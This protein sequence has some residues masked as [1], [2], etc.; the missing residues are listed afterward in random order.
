MQYNILRVF[1]FLAIV[2]R[3]TESILPCSCDRDIQHSHL[4]CRNDITVFTEEG[5]SFKNFYIN[6][7]FLASWTRIASS[8]SQPKRLPTLT[9]RSRSWL[10]DA[11]PFPGSQIAND[12]IT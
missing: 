7:I 5:K 10:S 3:K 2:P 12:L 6:Y 1:I 11:S 8:S 9:T 4:Q